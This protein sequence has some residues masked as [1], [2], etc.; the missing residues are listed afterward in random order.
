MSSKSPASISKINDESEDCP[1]P[2]EQPPP[3]LGSD[4]GAL[5]NNQFNLT[6]TDTASISINID[7]I[8]VLLIIC[9]FVVANLFSYYYF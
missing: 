5:T 4:S 8:Y 9:F 6:T 1:S 3:L 7:T 2:T